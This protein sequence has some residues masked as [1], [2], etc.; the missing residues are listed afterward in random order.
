MGGPPRPPFIMHK[1]SFILHLQK[2]TKNVQITKRVKLCTA[3]LYQ[4]EL[5]GV[6]KILK[7][8]LVLLNQT[9]I[10]HYTISTDVYCIFLCILRIEL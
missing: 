4:K 1:S 8:T 5:K 9:K 2:Q 6:T 10:Q 3:Q 7:R